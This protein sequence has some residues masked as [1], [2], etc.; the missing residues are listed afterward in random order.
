MIRELLAKYRDQIEI[1]HDSTPSY[2]NQ[3]LF[4]DEASLLGFKR[5]TVL[6]IHRALLRRARSVVRAEVQQFEQD[7]SDISNSNRSA[8]GAMGID[9]NSSTWRFTFV[10]RL[11]SDQVDELASAA[12]VNSTYA[13]SAESGAKRNTATKGAM[14]SSTESSF[15]K[16]AAR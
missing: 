3:M 7:F 15:P 13:Q 16:N 14:A 5:S 10:S 12:T 11:L 9:T 1:A 4:D 2:L 8:A 6:G